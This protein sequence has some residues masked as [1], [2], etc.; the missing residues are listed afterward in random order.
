MWFISTTFDVSNLET[1]R[2][3]RPSQPS[4]ISLMSVTFDVSNLETSRKLGLVH[5]ANM[6]LMS[7][8]F[9]VSNLETSRD[10][11]LMHQWN[12]PLMSV[13]FEV[14]RPERSAFLR[15]LKSENILRQSSD[16]E[17]TLLF[18]TTDVMRSFFSA[19]LCGPSFP[20]AAPGSGSIVKQPSKSIIHW[21]VPEVVQL[22]ET[23]VAEAMSPSSPESLSAIGAGISAS[24]LTAPPSPSSAARKDVADSFESTVSQLPPSSAC[25]EPTGVSGQS[26]TAKTTASSD[27]KSFSMGLA[28]AL[29]LNPPQMRDFT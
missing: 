13:A 26:D 23:L 7:V 17:T 9:D 21:Q 29:M 2:D 19:Q 10:V 14:S 18:M 6:R 1:S 12:I 3:L 27:L 15:F 8:T 24:G 4:N 11:R 28:K 25:A 16:E 20:D 22:P 5:D